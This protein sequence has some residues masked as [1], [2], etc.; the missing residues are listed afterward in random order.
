RPAGPQAAGRKRLTDSDVSARA[1][2][3]LGAAG[4]TGVGFDFRQDSRQLAR[5][6]LLAGVLVE[7]AVLL[8]EVA[9]GAGLH[10]VENGADHAGADALELVAGAAQ[11]ALG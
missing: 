1:S 5:E 8:A 2:G 10:T 3:R 6:D 4:A 7:L 9:A 11:R